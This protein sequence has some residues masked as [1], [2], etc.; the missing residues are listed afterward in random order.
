MKTSFKILILIAVMASSSIVMAD[1][2]SDNVGG[3]GAKHKSLF[4]VKTHKNL[5]GAQIEVFTSSGELLT[6]Q[7]LHRKKMIIDFCDA[8]LGIYTIKVTKGVNSK[9]FHFIKK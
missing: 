8:H 1:N 4:V 5:M 2:V 3:K 6:S 7:T 9:E